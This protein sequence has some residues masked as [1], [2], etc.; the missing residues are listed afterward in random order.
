MK[1]EWGEAS[2]LFHFDGDLHEKCR[3]DAGATTTVPAT[4]DAATV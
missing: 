3:Q 1:R 2:L 4:Y